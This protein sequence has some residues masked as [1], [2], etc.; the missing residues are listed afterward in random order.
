MTDPVPVLSWQQVT[1]IVVPSVLAFLTASL[2][3]I[4]AFLT[5]R[6][7]KQTHIDV[8][9]RLTQLIASN[10]R[11]DL[12]EGVIAGAAAARSEQADREAAATKNG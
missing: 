6:Q 4:V 3:T 1:V 10:R 11:A 9:S 2:G 5:L 8:N 7:S 12:A